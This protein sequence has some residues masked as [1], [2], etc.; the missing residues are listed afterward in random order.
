MQAQ[1]QLTAMTSSMLALAAV[2]E[3]VTGL[4]L[5]MASTLNGQWLFD[6]E[7]TFIASVVG[8]DPSSASASR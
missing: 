1:G 3:A 4:A 6:S 7:R 5:L 2:G 8:V